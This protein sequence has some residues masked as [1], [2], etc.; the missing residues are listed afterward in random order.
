MPPRR[1][2]TPTRA[3]EPFVSDAKGGL[4]DYKAVVAANDAGKCWLLIDGY[5]V[6]ATTFAKSGVNHRTACRSP[7]YSMRYTSCTNVGSH[8]SAGGYA[9]CA[10]RQTQSYT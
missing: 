5:V 4:I 7:S 6:D 1:G 3:R 9:T 2:A 8:G 10:S